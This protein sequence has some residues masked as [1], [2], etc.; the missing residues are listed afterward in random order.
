MRK[1]HIWWTNTPHGNSLCLLSNTVSVS[2]HCPHTRQLLSNLN[3]WVSSSVWL[4]P[5]FRLFIIDLF[6]TYTLENESGISRTELVQLLQEHYHA[7]EHTK[8]PISIHTA[9]VKTDARYFERLYTWLKK[10]IPIYDRAHTGYLPLNTT[11]E[12]LQTHPDALYH[13]QFQFEPYIRKLDENNKHYREK[14]Q[15]AS[16]PGS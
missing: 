4:L 10:H 1:S 13:F 3:V 16:L 8:G 2:I 6:Q 15:A 12:M 9:K 14:V 11:L 5:Q 7:R